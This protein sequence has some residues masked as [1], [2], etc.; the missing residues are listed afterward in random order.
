MQCPEIDPSIEIYPMPAFPTL[1]VS[2]LNASVRWYQNVLGFQHIATL[3][4]PDGQ[5]AVTHLRWAKYADLLLTPARSKATGPRGLGVTFYFAVSENR[6]DA[7]ADRARAAGSTILEGP[8]D[9]PWNIREVIIADPD[10]YRLSFG[11]G[12]LKP[13]TW[14]DVGQQVREQSRK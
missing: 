11:F 9:R 5:P 2:D 10:G 1:E 8:I 7:L 14:E 12:P 13:M 6:I 4:A 3:P